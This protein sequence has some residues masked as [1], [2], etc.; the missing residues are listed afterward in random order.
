MFSA[1]GWLGLDVLKAIES[2]IGSERAIVILNLFFGRPKETSQSRGNEQSDVEE[3]GTT[4][5]GIIT[6]RRHVG[7]CIACIVAS[8]SSFPGDSEVI[9]SNV[10]SIKSACWPWTPRAKSVI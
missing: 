2:E 10:K 5:L 4:N 8:I 7:F 6:S 9:G 1:N 3:N